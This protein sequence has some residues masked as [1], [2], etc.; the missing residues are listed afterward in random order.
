MDTLFLSILSLICSSLH[1]SRPTSEWN[2]F[3]KVSYFSPNTF[4]TQLAPSSRELTMKSQKQWWVIYIYIKSRRKNKWVKNLWK[5]ITLLEV[6]G[7]I[8]E[9]SDK[10]I[11]EHGCYIQ[12]WSCLRNF[13]NFYKESSKNLEFLFVFLLWVMWSCFQSK[14]FCIWRR[15]TNAFLG[16][17]MIIVADCWKD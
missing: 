6:K 17:K 12:S 5:K 7:R 1:M 16:V 11:S 3:K 10:S 15:G 14:F 4:K 9:K 13:L 8:D 2:E